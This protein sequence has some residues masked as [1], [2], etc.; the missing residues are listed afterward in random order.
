MGLVNTIGS[1]VGLATYITEHE[2][3]EKTTAKSSA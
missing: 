3:F 1:M 2:V